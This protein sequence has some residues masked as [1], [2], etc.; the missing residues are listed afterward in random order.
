MLKINKLPKAIIFDWDNTIIDT[1]PLIHGAID[2]TMVNMGKEPWGLEKVKESVHNSMRE[3]FPKIFGDDWEKAGKI[4]KDTYHADHL[5]K[6][7]MITNSLELINIAFDLGIIL[8]V[9]SNKVGQTLRDEVN[10]LG[11]KDK[12]FGVVG[13]NDAKYDKPSREPVDLALEG[14]NLSA[15]TDLI[16]FVGDSFV[17]IECGLNSGCK[18]VLFSEENK[19][20]RDLIKRV[21]KS[22][23]ESLL[24]FKNH[25][26]IID[27]LKN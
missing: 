1:W 25:Q 27:Y 21:Q 4:Y 7:V 6:L 20:S 14:S 15:E 16:W 12:F 10:H 3:S 13:A 2:K 11:L 26:E 9:V 18:P 24:Q 5:E 23:G 22:T 19:L 17:D 8:F